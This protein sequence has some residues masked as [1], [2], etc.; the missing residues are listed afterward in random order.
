MLWN[1][2]QCRR[3]SRPA[4]GAFEPLEARAMLAGFTLEAEAGQLTG[5]STS[6]A[7]RGYSGS[8]YVTGFDDSADRV[9]W[10]GFTADPGPYRMTIRFRSPYGQ[11]GFAG[12]LNGV[13]FSGMFPES[14]GF[15]S[16]DA[17]LV[18]LG[19]SNTMDL[20]GGWSYYEI[21]AVTLSPEQPVLPQPVPGVPVNPAASPMARALLARIVENYGQTTL[22]G[23]NDTRD[24]ALIASASGRLPAIVEGD[25][26]DYSPS[27]TAFGANPGPLTEN[28]I[29]MAQ[30]E[31]YL[32]SMAWHWN[33]PNKLVNAGDYP[34]WRGFYT[35][36]TTFDVA[37]ALADPAGSDYQ[38][39]LRDIDAIAGELEKFAAADVPVLWRPL[40]ESE[41]GW[42][43]WGAKGPEAF[44][45]LWRLV[46][47]RL[48]VHHGL[49][50]LV[51][52]LTS[53]DP[54]WY[55]GDDVVDI[56]GVDA[57]PGDRSDTLSSRWSPLL[58]R[59]DGKKP[60][61]LTEFGGVPDIEAMREVGVTWAYFAS[62]NG[63]YGPAL[64][65]EAKVRRIYTSES[66][67]TRDENPPLTV[68]TEPGVV[69]VAAGQ[70]V[71]DSVSRTGDGPLVK[72]GGGTLV[73]TAG[74]D[75]SGGTVIEEGTLVIR[76][77]AALGT[78]PLEVRAG[79]SLRLELGFGA[80]SL[81]GLIL[82]PA[83]RIDLGTGRIELAAGGF[84]ASALRE[85]VALGRN[86]GGWDAPAGIV[87]H[88]APA[89]SQ[90]AVGLREAGGGLSLAWAA[91]GDVNLDGQISI[92]DLIAISTS[93]KYGGGGDAGW[94]DGDT[95]GDGQ[96]TIGDIIAIGSTGLWGWPTYRAV[97]PAATAA[98]ASAA[99]PGPGA[100]AE[101]LVTVSLS[102]PT[103]N[104][105][106]L[107]YETRDGTALAGVDYTAVSGTLEFQPGETS[108]V[109]AVPILAGG[110]SA[111]G[112]AFEVRLTGGV[113]ATLAAT[114][115]T[116]TVTPALSSDV[117]VAFA[118]TNSWQGNFSGTVRI[119][120]NTAA[121]INGWTLEFDLP[122]VLTAGNLWGAEIVAVSGSRYRLRNAAW[123]ASIAAGSTVSF[124][125]NAAG[126]PDSEMTDKVFN[127]LPVA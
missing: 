35:P 92:G 34:W 125:F 123:T 103:T 115:V 25:F 77:P 45:Q 26:M 6:T 10:N 117:S 9:A 111:G 16:Y 99:R 17:G 1:R 67:I 61:A 44:K 114:A 4:A 109:I 69:S 3:R 2:R 36:G 93:G 75:F 41:G 124:S 22:A 58:E 68:V 24:L 53:E 97:I 120:N 88:A 82:D 55:P 29:A 122:A 19:A 112:G 70:T 80:I 20:G 52:V 21:D 87:S 84:D 56:I 37:A 74:G 78:G 65:T 95:N 76:D 101:A 90:R 32:V 62:W 23:Q 98:A 33:A 106:S 89:G 59:F 127:G 79:A 7:V 105:V 42:F 12:S 14:T 27:R 51:W 8:G 85:A 15:A 57:Y 121:A 102:E 113:A 72:R 126:L 50:N 47:D 118:V 86:G 91:Y 43:W 100:T 104:P 28:Y 63:S 11:K 5:T 18:T 54:A 94:A 30:D 31:G 116:V 107:S 49:D 38:A 81:P 39:I 64:E 108:R 48:T 96:V 13:A 71:T 46:Y 66:V 40:H 110:E 83:G 73:L 119:A 60:L